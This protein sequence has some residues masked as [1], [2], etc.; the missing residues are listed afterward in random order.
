MNKT[1]EIPKKELKKAILKRIKFFN[2][3]GIKYASNNFSKPYLN[4]LSPGCLTCINGTWSCIF[5][6]VLCTRNC[7]FCPQDRRI[8]KE[9]VSRADF[10]EFNS[11]NEYIDY[12]KKFDFEGIGFSGGE[13][14]LVFAKVIK[15]I[16]EIRKVFG[17]K[18]YIWIYTNG[19]LITEEKLRLLNKI[20]LNEIRFNL[21]A[22][23]YDLKPVELAVKYINVVTI[24]IPA[25]PEDVQLVKSL[26]KKFESIGVKY[27]N[28]HQLI[29][30]K[31]NY[32]ALMKKDYIILGKE[33]HSP[34]LD[35]ELAAFELL[36]Y[37]KKIK[38]NI[39]V[40]YCS[41]CYKARFQD[42]ALRKRYSP[43]YRSK[44][45]FITKTGYIRRLLINGS[46]N[47]LNQISNF[48]N[49]DKK[50]K[51]QLIKETSQFK[52][53]LSS[54]DLSRILKKFNDFNKEIDII[55]YQPPIKSLKKQGL[56]L[57]DIKS[58]KKTK[59]KCINLENETSVIF[60]Q[61][62]FIEEKGLKHSIEEL[63]NIY[64]LNKNEKP[65][66][67]RYIKAFYKKF[68]DLEYLPQDLPDYY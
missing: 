68:A 64:S 41:K 47:E 59:I 63:S 4:S 18:H 7:F 26:L 14:F 46:R 60:F 62:L 20:G 10:F 38:A 58:L 34:I 13:P 54:E 66:L 56:K 12:L 2:Y 53:I 67:V 48:L 52:L 17:K 65:K 9:K 19:D 11:V 21:S 43:F 61:K 50:Q 45:D 27:L 30:T 36:R 31:Y 6:N 25:I 37:T 28:I 44:F 49:Q 55:Y 3:D 15:Y 35:S 22:R 32:K 8:K 16:K 33:Q 29:M 42:K 40:N 39:G 51:F 23:N 57:N 24:E 5:I 1:K